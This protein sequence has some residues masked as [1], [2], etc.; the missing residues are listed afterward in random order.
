LLESTVFHRPDRAAISFSQLIELGGLEASSFELI[1]DQAF[2]HLDAASQLRL[3]E[4]WELAVSGEARGRVLSLI[5]SHL[6]PEE[7]A[8][9]YQVVLDKLEA[10]SIDDATVWELSVAF[11]KRRG[12]YGRLIELHR[13]W[14]MHLSGERRRSAIRELA[15]LESEFG[16]PVEGVELLLSLEN[17]ELF[18]E[19]FEWIYAQSSRVDLL[20]TFAV[21]MESLQSIRVE[22]LSLNLRLVV[23]TGIPSNVF[24]RITGAVDSKADVERVVLGV[25]DEALVQHA[26]ASALVAWLRL[27]H[28]DVTLSQSWH[29][30]HDVFL[31]LGTR[32]TFPEWV[33]PHA[34]LLRFWSLLRQ[35]MAL[36]HLS[37]CADIVFLVM[38]AMLAK[39]FEEE[40][41]AGLLKGWNFPCYVVRETAL[42][43]E[44][45][46]EKITLPNAAFAKFYEQWL[47]L[48]GRELHV[49]ARQE[50]LYSR[51]EDSDGLNRCLTRA[52]GIAESNEEKLRL[53]H[54]LLEVGRREGNQGRI[55]KAHARLSELAPDSSKI[56]KDF[57]QFSVS[58][59]AI[60]Q[61]LT[62]GQRA[63]SESMLEFD[64]HRLWVPWL[65]TRFEAGEMS[66]DLEKRLREASELLPENLSLQRLLGQLYF[67]L[68]R[69]ADG[70]DLWLTWLTEPTFS[71]TTEEMSFLVEVALA[72]ND[73]TRVQRLRSLVPVGVEFV[74]QQVC[75]ANG[76]GDFATSLTQI[77]AQ[78]RVG[79][80]DAQLCHYAL[81]ACAGKRDFSGVGRWASKGLQLGVSSDEVKGWVK[82]YVRHSDTL[83]ALEDQWFLAVDESVPS[84][85]ER[86]LQWLEWLVDAGESVRA[87]VEMAERFQWMGGIPESSSALRTRWLRLA[88]LTS[89]VEEAVRAF[90]MVDTDTP[91]L[92]DVLNYV[93]LR[94]RL[95]ML[96]AQDLVP[97]EH[98]VEADGTNESAFNLLSECYFELGL[99]VRLY[100]HLCSKTTGMT[101]TRQTVLM[102]WAEGMTGMYSEAVRRFAGLNTSALSVDA[103][104]AFSDFAKRG[105]EISTLNTW[106]DD[107]LVE[108]TGSLRLTIAARL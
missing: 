52:F 45:V 18:V 34:V 42:W 102:A 25:G 97:L 2:P 69:T 44:G 59:K 79:E 86:A 48:G 19:E 14:L 15:R 9:E 98:A 93:G 73:I 66:A 57:L 74:H 85:C 17:E 20:R 68:G 8:Q 77:E 51:L 16:D 95:G 92:E 101:S 31:T 56:A 103:F 53:A 41:R 81:I 3:L 65:Q 71:V 89:N 76:V 21:V 23:E 12:E 1:Y 11:F 24:K 4:G 70:L 62:A 49:L 75:L 78:D 36:A 84:R 67:A 22:T 29:E 91:L 96:E 38:E 47:S 80:L 58:V 106:C 82:P 100:V 60:D 54:A 83:N 40:L 43:W 61:I 87:G 55:L 26:E 6:D 104:T 30:L 35:T 32:S 10:F 37:N 5:L 108:A 46:F 64:E 105:A 94:F 50:A 63:F 7:D 90:E 13:R 28:D 39:G 88:A 99:W 27:L 33:T 72:S 107:A